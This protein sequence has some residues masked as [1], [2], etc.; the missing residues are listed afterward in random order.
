MKKI[1]LI[2]II[3]ICSMLF[4]S[5][6]LIPVSRL[7]A[8]F[9]TDRETNISTN[10]GYGSDEGS[11]SAGITT[12]AGNESAGT[13]A[14]TVTIS[15]EEYEKLPPDIREIV[16]SSRML[17]EWAQMDSG[18][19]NTIIAAGFKRSW[20]ARQELKQEL[21]PLAGILQ[22]RLREGNE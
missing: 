18:E 20:R 14:D 21:L 17:H 15:R 2:L 9:G 6:T 19:V 4:C 22:M 7:E 1:M 8:M 11:V 10:P 5:C 12:A 13:S 3:L 16:G